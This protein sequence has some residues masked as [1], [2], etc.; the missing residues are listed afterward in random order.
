MNIENIKEGG[1]RLA[2]EAELNVQHDWV[3]NYTKEN[4]YEKALTA[5]ENCVILLQELVK[6]CPRFPN[7]KT[8][9]SNA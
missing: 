7:D 6:V 5:A 8:T 2:L 1:I 9:S 3:K 4:G